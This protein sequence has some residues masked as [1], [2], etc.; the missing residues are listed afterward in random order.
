LK[1]K[2]QEAAAAN[3]GRLSCNPPK[4][5]GSVGSRL[6]AAS[7]GSTSAGEID[8]GKG[9]SLLAMA[10]RVSAESMA[11][12]ASTE[13]RRASTE[14]RS[15]DWACRMLPGKRTSQPDSRTSQ[16]DSRTSQ[17]DLQEPGSQVASARDASSREACQPSFKSYRL[18]GSD[19]EMPQNGESALVPSGVPQPSRRVSAPLATKQCAAQSRQQSAESGLGQVGVARRVS[20]ALGRSPSRRRS[21]ESSFEQRRRTC[22]ELSASCERQQTRRTSSPTKRRFSIGCMVTGLTLPQR[23]CG[24]VEP[25]AAPGPAPAATQ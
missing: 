16:P 15:M 7:R 24:R 14:N 11:R 22:E 1:R 25:S 12:R 21:E 4:S 13:N 9:A 17:P 2:K 20:A 3:Q 19:R 6:L 8:G 23:Q 10:R 5:V 18:D